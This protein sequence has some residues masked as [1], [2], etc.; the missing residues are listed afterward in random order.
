M[1][2]CSLMHRCLLLG[3]L[4]IVDVHDAIHVGHHV[5]HTLTPRRL[6]VQQ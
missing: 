5:L 3:V 1:V 4:V 6:C 2:I